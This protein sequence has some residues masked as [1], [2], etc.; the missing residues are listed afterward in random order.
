MIQ[1]QPGLFGD[2][3]ELSN[4][5]S[6]FI[7]MASESLEILLDELGYLGKCDRADHAKY[8]V[9]E[10]VAGTDQDST[11]SHVTSV[12]T[13][14]SKARSGADNN[15]EVL[16]R[17][18]EAPGSTSRFVI[19][20]HPREELVG[21]CWLPRLAAKTRVFLRGQMP[22]SYR[23]A[24]GSRLGVDGYFFRHFGLNRRTMI[25]A[26][27]ST[28]DDDALGKWFLA[29]PAVSAQSI[30]AWN[31]LAP[32][33]GAP[34]FPGHATLRVV[35]LFFYRKSLGTKARTLFEMLVADENLPEHP[36]HAATLSRRARNLAN[37][38]DRRKRRK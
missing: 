9:D 34:G 26:V 8:P 7:Q 37:P 19:L 31:K 16:A 18:R 3:C 38:A 6:R 35:S 25:N 15:P 14:S 12:R 28:A 10:A 36:M 33:L 5:P 24:F 29:R 32:Q 27:R 30:A 17:A 21:C 13:A 20:P 2:L 11:N 1:R 23:V 22:L 4:L